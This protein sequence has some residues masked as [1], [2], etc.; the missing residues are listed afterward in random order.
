M[1]VALPLTL[2]RPAAAGE[3]WSRQ[4]CLPV[5]RAQEQ[6]VGSRL[7][8]TRHVAALARGPGT[9]PDPLCRS[10]SRD[11]EPCSDERAALRWPMLI[12]KSNLMVL[13]FS[14]NG[15]HATIDVSA[16]PLPTSLRRAL[17][18][19]AYGS[20]RPSRCLSC[21][22]TISTPLLGVNWSPPFCRLS[23]SSNS[24]RWGIFFR[25]SAGR[26]PLASRALAGIDRHMTARKPNAHQR[27]SLRPI[28]RLTLVSPSGAQSPTLSQVGE[29]SLAKVLVNQPE[30]VCQHRLVPRWLRP[31][32]MG[33]RFRMASP[34][35]GIGY[36]CHTLD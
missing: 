35:Q 31:W 8:W 17:L 29:I 10:R 14:A 26:R 32:I 6:S 9:A 18:R 33:L 27:L 19:N 4:I 34:G 22:S 23:K 24:P 1:A 36:V 30:N 7:D 3:I 12:F 16:A 13:P 20:S 11:L 15:L 25:R 5:A 28:E 21:I 2:A